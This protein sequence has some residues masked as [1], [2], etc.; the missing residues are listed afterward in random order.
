MA[1][2]NDPLILSRSCATCRWFDGDCHCGL[3]WRDALLRGAILA[4][5]QVVCA[6]HEHEDIEGAAV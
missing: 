6:R 5:E 2:M 3:P 4:P 1:S